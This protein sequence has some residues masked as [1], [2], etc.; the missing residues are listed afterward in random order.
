MEYI[1]F[2]MGAEKMKSDKQ[3]ARLEMDSPPSPQTCRKALEQSFQSYLHPTPFWCPTSE[4][5]K[6]SQ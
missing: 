3:G 1:S 2:N 5:R 6:Q 4:E